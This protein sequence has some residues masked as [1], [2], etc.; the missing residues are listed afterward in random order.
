MNN[1]NKII[2]SI[3]LFS[4]QVATAQINT[5]KYEIGVGI[6]TFTY[7]GD[8]TPY[9]AGSFK[10]TS[11]GL[12]IHGSKILNSKFL[13]R[14]NLGIGRLK[15]NDASYDH[16][17]YRQQRN[18]RFNSPVIELSQLL[19]WSIFQR[20]YSDK[21]FSPYVFGGAGI[22]FLGIKRDWSNFNAAYFGDGSD[23]PERLAI[24]AAHK[25]PRIIPVIPVGA[26][27]RYSI[28]PRIA[29]SGESSYR[30]SFTDYLDGFSVA[31]NPS[32]NDHYHTV[33]IGA[34]YRIGKKNTLDCPIIRY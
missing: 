12:Q 3:S 34:I 31:A 14:T 33:S 7:Q 19:V 23:L 6:G 5:A 11:P 16:P 24:D 32:R 18:F 30:F 13:L 21:G 27:I 25:V 17:E 9:P 8:L 26:G 20:N 28:S 1:L 29:I 15:G 10:T 4:L 2:A 22:S